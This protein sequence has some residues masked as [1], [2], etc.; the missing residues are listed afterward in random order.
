M[1]FLRH[2]LR[3][4]HFLLELKWPDHQR[5]LIHLQREIPFLPKWLRPVQKVFDKL[6]FSQLDQSQPGQELND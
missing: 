3:Q 6:K 5:L 1:I 2:Q 4:Q